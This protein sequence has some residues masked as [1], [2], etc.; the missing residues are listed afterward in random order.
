M[1]I[2]QRGSPGTGAAGLDTHRLLALRPAGEPANE[3]DWVFRQDW[4]VVGLKE[5][6]DAGRSDVMAQACQEC[7]RHRACLSSAVLEESSPCFHAE[8]YRGVTSHW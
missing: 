2:S 8:E 1:A 7:P 6:Q 3:P 5:K 4:G